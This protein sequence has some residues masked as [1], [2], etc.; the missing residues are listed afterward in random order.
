[1][2]ACSAAKLETSFIAKGGWVMADF[3]PRRDGEL[4]E[5]IG[6]FL[7]QAQAKQAMLE[8]SDDELAQLS[9]AHAEMVRTQEQREAARAASRAATQEA[10]VAREQVIAMV[11]GL[12]ARVQSDATIAANDRKEMGLTVRK[13]TRTLTPD[14]TTTAAAAIDYSQPLMHRVRF[15]DEASPNRLGKPIGVAGCQIWVKVAERGAPENTL[16]SPEQMRF[17][18]MATRAPF[19][20]SFDAVDAGKQAM[21]RLRWVNT[22]GIVGPWGPVIVATVAG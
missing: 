2:G 15:F 14:P 4:L 13:R 7:N 3:L 9:A 18:A 5:W 16:V 8:L 1:M 22:R 21:Y 20:V 6:N 10:R 17:V 12:A 19:D 11:R